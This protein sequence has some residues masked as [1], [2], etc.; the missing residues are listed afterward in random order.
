MIKARRLGK[1]EEDN[2]PEGKRDSPRLPVRWAV[3]FLSAAVAAGIAYQASG[4]VP[5][6]MAGIATTTV[7]HQILA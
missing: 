2:L 7:L 6:L 1:A 3:I 5:A 4:V